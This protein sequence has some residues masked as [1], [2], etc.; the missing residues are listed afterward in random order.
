MMQ[1]KK[2]VKAFLLTLVIQTCIAGL[3]F[4][5]GLLDPLLG[6]WITGI[7]FFLWLAFI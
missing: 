7:Y 6:L 5:G 4:L 2:K 1:T 3:I